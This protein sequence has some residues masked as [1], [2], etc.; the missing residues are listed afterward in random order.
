MIRV[1]TATV[2]SFDD[3]NLTLLSMYNNSPEYLLTS[4]LD[5]V[6]ALKEYEIVEETTLMNAVPEVGI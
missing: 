2:C 1:D 6:D 3:T 4:G 5:T